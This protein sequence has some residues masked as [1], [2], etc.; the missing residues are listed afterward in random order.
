MVTMIA[1]P[2]VIDI[3]IPATLPLS[4][5]LVESAMNAI[6]IGKPR[7]REKPSIT[8]NNCLKTVPENIG[9]NNVVATPKVIQNN[10]NFLLL[11]FLLINIPTSAEIPAKR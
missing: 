3:V 1:K 11:D 7:P 8:L 5:I 6:L 9:S 4:P 2:K 10:R